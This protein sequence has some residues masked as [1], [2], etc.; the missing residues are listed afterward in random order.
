MSGETKDLELKYAWDWFSYHAQ[1]RLTAFNFFLILMSAAVLGY[2]QAVNNGLPALGAA[3]GL[4]GS[5]VALAFWAMDVRN[6]ELVCCGRAAL[7]ELEADLNVSIRT[8]DRDR[9]HLADAMKGPV[10]SKLRPNL[11][12]D[13]FTHRVWLRRVIVVMGLLSLAAAAWAVLGFPGTAEASKQTVV[14]HGSKTS[15]CWVLRS[16]S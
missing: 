8:S 6:E 15:P 4:L 12:R 11:A 2:T 9:K 7:D 16:S 1:Q 14:C 3:L 5:F 10:A 13:A